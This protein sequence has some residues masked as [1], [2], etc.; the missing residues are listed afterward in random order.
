MASVAREEG[1]RAGL[2]VSIVHEPVIQGT[3]GGIRGLQHAL[4][5][6]DPVVVWNGDILFAPDV[7]SIVQAHV[8]SGAAATMLLLPM[9]PGARYGAV[10]TDHSGIVRRI[11]ATGVAGSGLRRWHF[12]GVH[13]LSQAVFRAMSPTGPEDIN[14]DVYPRLF[15][16]GEVRGNVVDAPWSDL[17]EPSTY[18]DAQADVL[19]G[20]LADPLG[21]ASPLRGRLGSGALVES[22]ARVHSSAELGADVFVASG[23]EVPDGARV[24]RAAL[25]PG[26]TVRPGEAVTGEIRWS[27]GSLTER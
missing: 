18:L 9:P 17:G 20:R 26:A 23:V 4:P 22:G 25:L 21:S 6:D 5:G 14:R 8:A 10:E 11:S 2:A 15:P 7:A 12:S 1:A 3:G 16:G 24:H 19:A 27:G 13:V